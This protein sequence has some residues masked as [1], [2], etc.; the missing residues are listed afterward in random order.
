MLSTN[1]YSN[2]VFI[3]SNSDF[4]IYLISF[5]AKEISASL[6]RISP[7]FFED[8]K[9]ALLSG[10]CI[11]HPSV[12]IRKS[13]LSKNEPVYKVEYEPAED[14]ELW[15]RLSR[16]T[17]LYNIQEILLR[18][19]YHNSQVSNIKSKEQSN[20]LSS[21]RYQM[22]SNLTFSLSK[23]EKQFLIS[24]LENKTID[25]WNEINCF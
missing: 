10:N 3:S 2:K 22:I 1:F 14:Y 23:H 9:I 12:L 13:V 25:S 11:A 16:S 5:F 4:G 17:K 8:I 19:R 18:Y 7:C 15:V 21:L 24:V 6:N 20:L